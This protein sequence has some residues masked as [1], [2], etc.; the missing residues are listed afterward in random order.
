MDI[1]QRIKQVRKESGLTQAKFADRLNLKKST[2]GN[3]EV[4]LLI[5]SDRTI[6]D[7][8]R[9]FDINETWLRTGE[10]EMYVLSTRARCLLGFAAR[11]VD[12]NEESFPSRFVAACSTLDARDWQAIEKLVRGLE[13]E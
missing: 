5:P 8:C 11:L 12:S 1:G 9:V 4:G 2:V 10:G 3:Y 7:I 13:R 6:A